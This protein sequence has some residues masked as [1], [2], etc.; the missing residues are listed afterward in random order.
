MKKLTDAQKWKQLAEYD[1]NQAASELGE[2]P[3][4]KAA[5][6]AGELGVQYML[7]VVSR[8]GTDDA[9][10]LLRNLPEDFA[11][12]I[13]EDLR[14]DKAKD[15]KEL[16]SYSEETAGALMAK[17]FLAVPIDATIKE[18][19]EYLQAIPQDRKGKVSYIYVVDKN[20]R[21]LGVIQVRDLIFY[22]PSKPVE[23]ILKSPVVQVETGMLQLDVAK[24]LQRHHYLGLPVV[25]AAQKLVGVI[26]AD[27][28][29][30]VFEKE[31][32][33]DIARLVG[34]GAEEVRTRSIPR[35]MR[36][37][38]PWLFV[39]IV[40]GLACAVVL[41]LFKN[42]MQTVTAL[43]LFIPV[44]L[45]LSES[46]GVQGATI[47]VRNVAL[48]FDGFKDL[49][50]LFIKEVV[51]GI[52]IGIICGVIVGATASFWRGD[53]L[54][55]IALAASMTLSIIIS[56]LIGLILPFLFKRLKIDPAMASGPL[57][58]AI[59][60]IQTLCVY[61]GVSSAILAR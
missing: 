49:R 27:S 43:F 9:A 55:G 56:A 33:E 14:P 28:A 26:S 40:S 53:R 13:L 8:L 50:I 61:F 37:R 4:E 20:N 46:T 35:I 60:D 18:A 47:V 29:L 31:A 44:V 23:Q 52:L 2:Q 24:L 22:P 54:L 12:K 3:S 30:Q 32:S 7:N 36:L 34:T 17:E 51:V 10:E 6:I 5:R 16:L 25:D 19:T 42:N 58:L 59:C 41:D 39:S 48:K 45:G 21:L 11:K 38:L 1:I 57:V 15:L